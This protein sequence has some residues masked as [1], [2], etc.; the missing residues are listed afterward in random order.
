MKGFR[1]FKIWIHE[2]MYWQAA[3]PFSDLEVREMS[4]T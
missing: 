4:W 2:T 1:N 3:L